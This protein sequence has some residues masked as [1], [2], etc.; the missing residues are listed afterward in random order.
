MKYN[1]KIGP[2]QIL[3]EEEGNDRNWLEEL[4]YID[5]TIEASSLSDAQYKAADALALAV[6]AFQA[7]EK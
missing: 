7:K 6:E 5:T 3:V 4:V 1:V 2:L